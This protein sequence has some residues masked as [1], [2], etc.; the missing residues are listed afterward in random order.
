MK[1]KII[2]CL[3]IAFFVIGVLI[4]ILKP[5]NGE[6]NVNV[7]ALNGLSE[8][9]TDLYKYEQKLWLDKRDHEFYKDEELCSSECEKSITLRTEEEKI[10]YLDT[11]S[12][13]FYYKDK[14]KIKVYNGYNDKSYIINIPNDYDSYLFGDDEE[15][16]YGVVCI[17]DQKSTYY[18]LIN[19]KTLY[20]EKYNMLY[21]LSRDYLEGTDFNKDEFDNEI[22]DKIYLLSSNE[23]KELISKTN[24]DAEDKYYSFSRINENNKDYYV[25]EIYL[26]G[27]NKTESFYK[28]IYNKNLGI[29]YKNNYDS[30]VK[31]ETKGEDEFE[32]IV[33]NN[34]ISRNGNLFVYDNGKFSEY[35]YNGKEIRNTKISGEYIMIADEY[36]VSIKNNNLVLIDI[37]GKETILTKMTDNMFVHSALSGWFSENGKD[38]VY[39]VVEVS[40]GNAD[41]IYASCKKTNNCDNMSRE[42]FLE[43][44]IGYEY[45]YIPK[46]GEVGKIG[47]YIGGYAKPILYLYPE[48]KTNVTVTF[49]NDKSLTTT[50]PKYNDSW[51]VTAYP[52]GDLYDSNNKYYYGLYWEEEL[53]HKIDFSEGFYVTKENAIEFLESKL[54]YIGFNERERN[55]FIMYWLPILEKNGRSLVY[56]ELTKERDEYS[57][58]N[59]TPKPDSMLRVA[60]HVKK[61]N[62]EVKI[63]EQ[64]LE[65]FERIGFSAIEWGGVTY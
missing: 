50:Y 33:I 26:A 5:N 39:I 7:D 31:I 53:N 54:E 43:N 37:N 17:K 61:V 9:I 3:I 10:E 40:D 55:E 45:Y 35:D 63:K 58:I 64:K 60:I 41:E 21:P 36:V 48:T 62:N 8:D 20:K 22:Q 11:S 51:N 19:N 47:T 15:G 14:N 29:I 1:D 59:I 34:N 12:N 57:K 18:N 28:E 4:L 46:T 65:R 6:V 44:G 52:S 25:F 30:P 2:K 23:E 32:T 56:F 49:E 27:G 42:D 13:Y 38:G 16:L 24:D